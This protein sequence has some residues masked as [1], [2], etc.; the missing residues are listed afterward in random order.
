VTAQP[1]LG[2]PILCPK[3]PSKHYFGT[4]KGES[5]PTSLVK[6]TKTDVC[7][8]CKTQLVPAPGRQT[9]EQHG[10]ARRMD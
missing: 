6:Y 8:N 10:I 2:L 5:V 9:G 7:P 3:C 1:T 4:L